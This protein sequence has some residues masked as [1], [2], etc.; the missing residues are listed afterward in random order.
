MIFRF[1]KQ[2]Y[3]RFS[4]LE[5]LENALSKT[6]DECV[7]ME[8]KL[9]KLAFRESQ[10]KEMEQSNNDLI[11]DNLALDE[12]VTLLNENIVKREHVADNWTREMR[13][14]EE[15]IHKIQT[16]NECLSDSKAKLLFQNEQLNVSNMKLES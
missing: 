7:E 14:L 6:N 10:Y 9:K 11:R 15:K 16:S 3:V 4:S 1:N 13:F 5:T 12:K 8:I 2:I